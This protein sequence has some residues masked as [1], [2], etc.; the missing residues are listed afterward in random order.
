MSWRKIEHTNYT[1]EFSEPEIYVDNK[2]R[3]RSGHMTHAM[4]EFAP[5]CFIDFNSNCSAVRCVGHSAFGWVESRVSSDGG[6]TYSEPR[7][8][9]YS[10][11]SFLDGCFTVS[12]EKAVSCRD[13]RIVAFCLRNT[14]LAEVC[15]E[16]WLTPMFT[17]SKDGGVT[18]TEPKELSPYPGRPYDAICRD[19]VIY[20]LH[21]CNEH[22]LGSKPEHQYR[23]Y[24]STDLGETFEE[25]SIIPFDTINR[26]YGSILFDADGNLHAY[27]YHEQV[28]REMDHAI[29]KDG[30]K[31]WTLLKPCY[32]AKGIRNPQTALI[33]G[34]Y[35]LHGRAENISGFVFY[36]SENASDWDEGLY[37]IRKENSFCFYSNNLNLRDEEGNFLLVQYSDTYADDARVNVMHTKLRI[38]RHDV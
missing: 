5:N 10:K 36:T 18:W 4:A 16:P 2:A 34:V 11:E 27:A 21:F 37:F 38:K 12:V 31:T 32:L 1:V 7:E 17:F 26:G 29:S 33:D 35:I 28:E 3:R 15:C 9:P 22:F 14:T 20:V 23:L 6:K 13:G 30:G 8:F 19:D 25:Y 24:R